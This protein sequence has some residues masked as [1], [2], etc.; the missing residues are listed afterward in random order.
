MSLCFLSPCSKIIE[1]SFYYKDNLQLNSGKAPL[2][3]VGHVI[4]DVLIGRTI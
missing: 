3:E 1:H 2:Q 4:V